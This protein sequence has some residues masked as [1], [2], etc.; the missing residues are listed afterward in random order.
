MSLPAPL[1]AASRV[2][3]LVNGPARYLFTR[4]LEP[5]RASVPVISVGNIACGGTGKTPTVAA[6]VRTLAAQGHRPAILTRGYRRR[7]R[8]PVLIT[9][10]RDADWR[11]VG[12]EPAHLARILPG[13]PIVVDADRLRAAAIAVQGTRATH[14]VLDDGLQHFRLARDLD[15]VVVDAADPLARR[16]PRREHPRVLSR[17]GA[18]VVA[19]AGEVAATA[20]AAVRRLAPAATVVTTRVVAR[21][22]HRGGGVEPVEVLRGRRLLAVAGIAAPHR[23]LATLRG[24]GAEPVASRFFPDHHPFS[25]ADWQD[26]LAQAQRAGLRVVTTGKDAVKVPR[27]LAADVSWL[28]VEAECVDGSFDHLLRPVLAAVG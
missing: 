16:T 17:A 22:L 4:L 19:N 21:R 27:H 3:E 9:D 24:L 13:V 20:V 10:G 5:Q 28:E 8:A 11:A 18:I 7:T 23:F 1:L 2:L 25:E 6:L 12:D 26:I 15:V 14:L